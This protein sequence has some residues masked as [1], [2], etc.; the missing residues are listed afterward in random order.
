MRLASSVKKFGWADPR[1]FAKFEKI[2]QNSAEIHSC[3][4]HSENPVKRIRP[5]WPVFR[6]EQTKFGWMNPGEVLYTEMASGGGR[7]HGE[8]GSE[9]TMEY[10]AIE[11][12]DI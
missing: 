7:G 5:V 12:M 10:L 2:R 6:P 4:M 8:K 1:G 11:S 9:A 3:S